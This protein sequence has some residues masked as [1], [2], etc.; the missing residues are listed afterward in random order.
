MGISAVDMLV[1]RLHQ[2]AT[3]LPRLAKIEK[4]EGDWVEGGTLRSVVDLPVLVPV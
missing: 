4:V 3:G 2:G 1:S